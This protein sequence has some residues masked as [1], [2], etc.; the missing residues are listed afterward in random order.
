[1]TTSRS[2]AMERSHLR[3]V[4]VILGCRPPDRGLARRPQPGPL[5]RVVVPGARLEIAEFLVRHLVELAE[6]LND[7]LILVAMIGGDVVT[8]AVPQR[9]PDDRHLFLSH[10]L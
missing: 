6:E 10:Q 5:R 1:M 4:E 2:S 9:S 7:L 8:G 3:T